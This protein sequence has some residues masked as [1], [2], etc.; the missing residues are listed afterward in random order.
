[1]ANGDRFEIL[2][3]LIENYDAKHYAIL[4]TSVA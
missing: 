3:M 1:M 4:P 2:V